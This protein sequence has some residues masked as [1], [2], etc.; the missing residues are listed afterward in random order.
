MIP[1]DDIGKVAPDGFLI[2]LDFMGS[3]G[4][5]GKLRGIAFVMF[6]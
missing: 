6:F 1:A 4:F 5:D 3:A 2:K